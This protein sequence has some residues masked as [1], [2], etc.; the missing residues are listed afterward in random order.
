MMKSSLNPHCRSLLSLFL[1]VGMLLCTSCSNKVN[2]AGSRFWHGFS[3]RYNTYFNGHEAFKEGMLAKE[4]GVK[5]NYT[6]QLP[7]FMVGNEKN[8]G[9]G[10][11]NFETCVEKM[12]KAITQHSIKKR[13]VRNSSKALTPAEKL[14]MQ[15]K[16][17]NP[18][19]KKAWLLMGQA[20]FQEGEFEQ[21]AATFNYICRL[22]A[23]EPFVVA[24]ARS[25]LARCY[26]Q[27]GWLYDAEDVLNRQSRD[28]LPPR[29]VPERDAT[30]AD[31]LLRQG[32][33]EEA[34]PFLD[35]TIKHCHRKAQKARL[36]FLQAQIKRAL[37]DDDGAY[38]ALGKCMGQSPSYEV[39]FNARIMQTEV[40]GQDKSRAKSMVRRLKRM[41]RADINKD[42]LDQ[43]YYAMGNIY[44]TQGDTAAA[45]GAFESG[46]EKATRSGIEKGVLLLRLGE[47]YWDMRRFD[48]AQPCYSEC[49]SMIGKEHK[50]YQEVM[51]R[52]KVL[53]ELVPY[54]SAVYLQDS[55]QTLARLPEAE[56]NEAIDRVIEALKKKEAEEKKA[57]R[58]S[59]AQA[60]AEANGAEFDNNRNQNQNNANQ[61]AM[62]G[63]RS[64]YFYNMQ[65]VSQGK[66]DFRRQWGNR[67][68]ED[69]WRRSNRTVV[70][71]DSPSGDDDG[72]DTDEA[73]TDSLGNPIESAEVM[74][75]SLASATD[76]L[77]LDPH[78]REY[79][80]AQIPFTEEQMEASHEIIRDGLYNAGV[81]EKDKLDDFALAAETLE[82]L[83]RDYPEATQMEDALYHM[84]LLYSRW[85]RPEIADQY[86]QQLAQKFPDG[87]MTRMITD[88]DFELL[89]RYGLQMEDSLYTETYQAYRDRRTQVVNDNYATSTRR[90]P[91]GLNRPKFIFVHALANLGVLPSDSIIS[92][93]RALVSEFPKADVA[94][95]AGMIVKGLESGRTIGDGVYD[96]GSLWD[97]R[98]TASDEA[99]AALKDKQL[100]PDRLVPFTFIF[101][102]PT[103]SVNDDRLLYEVAHFNFNSFMVRGFEL[104]FEKVPGLTQF[105]IQGFNSYDEAHAY[106]QKIY[107]EANIHSMLQ[108]GRIVL[109]SNENLPLL[110]VTV[111]YEQYQTYFDEH[112]AP[113]QLPH[114]VKRLLEEPNIET[115]YE[116][117]VTVPPT[118][119]DD[120]EGI[121]ADAAIEVEEIIEP[122]EAE[123][124]PTETD[125]LP[126]EDEPLSTED[127]PLTTEPETA[128]AQPEEV[129]PVGEEPQ[130][131]EEEEPVTTEP[132]SAPA[133]EEEVLPAE[134]EPVTTEEEVI[135]DEE[136]DVTEEEEVIIETDG[137]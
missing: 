21:A 8:A 111:S 134:K 11:G 23:A 91:T 89:A 95:M 63:D 6:E 114:D 105:R 52:S 68:N 61:G 28:S 85:G 20:Q 18:F 131:A 93:L 75:D 137:E 129:Q 7:L 109:I 70:S 55:L 102:Y 115:K 122:I 16:E 135:I 73:L 57:R 103:D 47:L 116:D 121:D 130:P 133:E 132:E 99:I 40:L 92:E 83:I 67:K 41:A 110:G 120:A 46:R 5:D 136:G 104:S 126:T 64:W 107:A 56:R 119:D 79:Y 30:R 42:Y 127:E 77:A 35:N 50:R 53:D 80:L 86:R 124:I 4:K 31:L 125:P 94:E 65:A 29:L 24:E 87:V 9:L 2:T 60:R 81:I 17:F 44:L 10:K 15:R 78:N 3:A 49:I 106:A 123:A 66:Q 71:M 36:Y 82:R 26:A 62:S 74:G 25:W 14:Y 84:F 59:A 72:E 45:I 128:P 69:D 39:Q 112:Y 98:A 51:K 101:A 32:R 54:T 96:L 13:P 113:L 33:L 100:V 117:E 48:K 76:S 88:P 58:D 19:L 34:L 38:R 37:G 43:V 1:V 22:Y 97:R 118:T 27:T 108:Q 12:Q 90:F